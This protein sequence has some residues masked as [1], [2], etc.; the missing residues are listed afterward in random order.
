MTCRRPLSLF[1]RRGFFFQTF[2]FLWPS[3]LIIMYEHVVVKHLPQTQ[4]S[5]AQLALPKSAKQV[6]AGQSA[7]T[8]ASSQSW[9]ELACR[10]AFM[11]LAASWKRAKKSKSARQKYNKKKTNDTI[12][13]FL[14]SIP[15]IISALHVLLPLSRNSDQGSHKARLF[16]TTV[17]ALYFYREK[18]SALSTLVHSRRIVPA[19]AIIGALD[20]WCH[21]IKTWDN[22]KLHTVIRIHHINASGVRG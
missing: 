12:I 17:R 16:S 8:Q 1:F 9:R 6:R 20:S 15:F 22:N 7:T 2:C 4:H 14:F 3:S 13:S 19:H 10:R 18:D 11:Q 5:K 21:W